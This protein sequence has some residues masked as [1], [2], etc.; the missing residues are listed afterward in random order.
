M[1]TEAVVGEHASPLKRKR[2]E[3]DEE[4]DKMEGGEAHSANGKVEVKSEGDANGSGA[5]S[6]PSSGGAESPAGSAPST[7]AAKYAA[8]SCKRC[9]KSIHNSEEAITEHLDYHYARCPRISCFF[10]L[11]IVL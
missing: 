8:F 11:I 7:V 1:E 10:A 3:S 2:D 9:N 4:L 6:A 5:K